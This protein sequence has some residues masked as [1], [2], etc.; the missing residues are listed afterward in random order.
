MK[1]V[2]IAIMSLTLGACSTLVTPPYENL[3][4]NKSAIEKIGTLINVG[5]FDGAYQYDDMCRGVGPIRPQDGVTVAAYIR[6]ALIGELKAGGAFSPSSKIVLTG[7]LDKVQFS[8]S[9]G[10]VGGEWS[11]D[12]RIF[13]SNGKQIQV[14]N[15]FEFS[16]GFAGVVACRETAV[17]FAPAVQSLITKI[18][19]DQGFR[20]LLRSTD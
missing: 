17:A 13:S 12:M 11:F 4:E 9:K 8:S 15:S 19:S 5:K 20:E 7:S 3:Y 18:L 2:A 14:S 1:F 10:L 16:S 6:N